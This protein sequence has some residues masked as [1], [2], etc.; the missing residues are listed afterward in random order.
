M[1]EN[2][3]VMMRLFPDLFA[4]NSVAPL[5]HYPHLRLD[6]LAD[7]QTAGFAERVRAQSNN[8]IAQPMLALLNRHQL[9]ER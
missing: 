3:N 8:C 9:L 1:L 4:P 7:A 5:A 2:R 6:N